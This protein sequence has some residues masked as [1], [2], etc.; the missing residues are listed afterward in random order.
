M[1]AACCVSVYPEVNQNMIKALAEA[2]L[3][4]RQIA[5]QS[6]AIRM[7]FARCVVPMCIR[8]RIVIVIT[9]R[10]GRERRRRPVASNG[11]VQIMPA[12]SKQCMDEQRRTQQATK[13]GT[14]EFANS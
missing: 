7:S 12:T 8:R 11:V 2:R 9:T 13:N 5:A 4:H 6:M 3:L 10:I 14:H 1:R